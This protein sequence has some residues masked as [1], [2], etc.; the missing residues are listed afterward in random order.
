MFKKEQIIREINEIP[1]QRLEEVYQFVHALNPK[2]E[3]TVA[4]RKKIMA[5]AGS[6][7]DMESKAWQSFAKTVK[8]TR[9]KLF[10]RHVDL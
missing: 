8:R 7:A 4:K 3:S 6:F 5:Y 2:S 10:N 9:R 1:A